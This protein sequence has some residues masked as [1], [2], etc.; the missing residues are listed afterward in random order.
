[1]K[2]GLRLSRD[3]TGHATKLTVV[4]DEWAKADPPIPAD[5]LPEWLKSLGGPKEVYEAVLDRKRPRLTKDQGNAA[6]HELVEAGFAWVTESPGQFAGLDGDYLALVHFDSIR[7]TI[8]FRAVDPKV[9]QGWLRRNAKRLLAS[10]STLNSPPAT[11]RSD[12]PLDPFMTEPERAKHLYEVTKAKTAHI[13]IDR[14]LEPAAGTGA[15]FNLLPPDR[16][17]G[18]DIKKRIEGVIEHDFLTFTDFGDYVYGTI[19]NFPFGKN[20]PIRFFNHAARVSRFIALIAP[21]T[22]KKPKTVNQL[23]P[24]F[25]LIHEEDLPEN[26]FI[27][28]GQQEHIAAIFQIWEKRA[29]KRD[30]IPEFSPDTDDLE[31]LPAARSNEATIWFQR[32]GVNAGRIKDPKDILTKSTS[33]KSHFFIKCDPTSADILRSISW[34]DLREKGNGPPSITQTEIIEAYC[35]TKSN[36]SAHQYQPP[37]SEYRSTLPRPGT[38]AD[39][40]PIPAA[41]N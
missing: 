34:R 2:L 22:F 9:G 35:S 39:F 16:R 25:H 38:V 33:P 31:F 15:F 21:P 23:D 13:A 32:L 1:V 12:V 19:G 27:L 8:G 29:A 40:S 10:R 5:Q 20:A 3:D 37:G 28:G 11:P 6:F 18:I 14:W 26:S 24:H 7:R 41:A 17:L 30:P 36:R 4:L